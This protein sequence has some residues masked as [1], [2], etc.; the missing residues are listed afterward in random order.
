M[1]AVWV[2]LYLALAAAALVQAGLFTLHG[3]ENRRFARSRHRAKPQAVS[4]HA[5][6]FAPCKGKDADMTTSLLRLLEQDYPDYEVVFIVESAD[7]LAL[8]AIRA[9]MA[10]R[11]GVPARVCIAGRATHS[12][13]KVHNLLAATAEL[14]K[15]T[16]YLA[17]VDSD[18]QTTPHWLRS[19]VVRLD[20]PEVGAV[21]GY[22]W[23][24][25]T[26]NHPAAFALATINAFAAGLLG[27][28][29]HQLVWGGSWAIRKKTFLDIRLREAWHGA[30]SDDLVASRVINRAGLLTVFEPNCLVASPLEATT[31][32]AFE[33]LRRQYLIGRVYATRMWAGAISVALLS[34]AVLWGSLLLA[35]A[36]FAIGANH[37]WAPA[38]VAAT[39]WISHAVRG[40]LR[41]QMAAICLP[42]WKN[43]LA[44]SRW[45]DIVAAPVCGL[46]NLAA[47]VSSLFGSSITW[48]GNRYRLLPG[49]Q[50]ERPAPAAHPTIPAPH[51]G[52]RAPSRNSSQNQQQKLP[53][54]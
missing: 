4:G 54:G 40:Y 45:V 41:Q 10:Q 17:F 11:P 3:F 29:G 16:E 6:L 12:G 39:L 52:R 21:T 43:Q 35:M 22:R 8:P 32:G 30:L 15:Q 47:I 34:T 49:G 13:Q 46:F 20:R 44:R 53:P 5:M 37:A 33:F 18:A 42:Q 28:G 7:D 14:P 23:F 50:I 2:S 24:I 38:A 1:E 31:A 25:P 26:N 36:G 51:I 48:R 27:P 19:L 9:A